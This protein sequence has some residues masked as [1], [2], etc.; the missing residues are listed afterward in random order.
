MEDYKKPVAV[1]VNEMSEGVYM[2]SG[3]DTD[4]SEETKRRCR[5]GFTE[6]N[7]GRD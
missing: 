1:S 3:D 6:A 5:F 4:N 7:L 2:A